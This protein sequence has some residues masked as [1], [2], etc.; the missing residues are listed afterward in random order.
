MIFSEFFEDFSLL[1]YLLKSTLSLIIHIFSKYRTQFFPSKCN[2]WKILR[3]FKIQM[4]GQALGVIFYFPLDDFWEMRDFLIVDELGLWLAAA[5]VYV[6]CQAEENQVGNS[7]LS[8]V[9]QQLCKVSFLKK[10]DKTYK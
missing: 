5:A 8:S 10:C 2:K 7:G 6:S 1:W 4:S 9:Q 3:N